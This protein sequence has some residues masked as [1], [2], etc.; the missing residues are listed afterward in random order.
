MVAELPHDAGLAQEVHTLLLRVAH[1][2]C[3]D[4]H[5]H[6]LL[7]LLQGALVDLPEFSC[8]GQQRSSKRVPFSVW[9]E[10]TM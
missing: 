5:R 2:E 7:A 8:S 10:M 6:L 9:G 1:L 4:G 3:L